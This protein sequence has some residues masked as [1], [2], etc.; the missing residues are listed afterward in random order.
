MTI[1][2][3]HF[4]EKKKTACS[5]PFLGQEKFIKFYVTLVLV[6]E[7]YMF[8]GTPSSCLKSLFSS[9]TTKVFSSKTAHFQ[10]KIE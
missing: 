2:K 9:K 4:F 6:F 1:S 3:T 5:Y 10:K 8:W 7:A